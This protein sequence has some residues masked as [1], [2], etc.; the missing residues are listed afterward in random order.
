MS[1]HEDGF[2]FDPERREFTEMNTAGQPITNLA[3]DYI[4][5]G[6]TFDVAARQEGNLFYGW[7]YLAS[8]MVYEHID[9]VSRYPAGI[10]DF[11]NWTLRT[12]AQRL[13]EVTDE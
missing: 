13:R 2:T 5:D 6:F 8:E 4:R 7:V 12:F 10:E 1:D 11:A 3:P 9:S